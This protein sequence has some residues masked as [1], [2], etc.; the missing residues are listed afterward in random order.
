MVKI[1]KK[2]IITTLMLIIVSLVF[3]GL[4][5]T[6]AADFSSSTIIANPE[7]VYS[8]ENSTII[9]TVTG[10]G[11]LV[12]DA[13]VGIHVEAGLFPGGTNIH[14]ATTDATGI[15]TVQWK[16]PLV[17]YELFYNFTAI[18]KKE[19]SIN[20]TITEQVLVKP[21]TFSGTTFV[22]NP[23]EINEEETT[24]ISVIVENEG[25][26]IEDATVTFTGVGGTF[27]SSATDTSTGSSDAVGYYEDIWTAPDVTDITKYLIV[28]DISYDSTNWTYTAELNVTVNPAEG[29]LILDIDITPGENVAVGQIVTIDIMVFEDAITAPIDA[30]DG[31][32]VTFTAVD[33]NF[34]EGGLDYYAGYTNSSGMISVHW[35]TVDLTP[36]ILGTDYDIDIVASLIGTFTNYTTLTFNVKEYS[37]VLSITT[38]SDE[39]TITLGDS[40]EFTVTVTI[41][42]AA[43]ENAYVQ[44]QAQS[45]VFNEADTDKITGYTNATGIFTAIWNTSEMVMVGSDPLNYTF[46]IT[47]DIFPNYLDQESTLTILVNPTPVTSSVTD[48]RGPIYTQWWFYVAAG[49]IIIG[50]GVVV[51]LF[52]RKK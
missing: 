14:N 46:T 36:A 9:V 50:I 40:V 23:I 42:G 41:D 26:P 4:S 27:D 5:Y 30:I 51:I 12:E 22:A 16:S 17:D 29:Q 6:R 20:A 34:T 18:I 13:D 38:A 35:E 48:P 32:F 49:G 10:T 45:G 33:G 31:V 7:T 28:L 2:I 47:V 52:T 39:D 1:T 24:T 19:S 43:V 44:I 3:P 21:V 37:G 25:T 11:G 15:I 8:L